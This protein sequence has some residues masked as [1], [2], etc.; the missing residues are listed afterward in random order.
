MLEAAAW[1][2]HTGRVRRQD[3]RPF[4]G[5]MRTECGFVVALPLDGISGA[6]LWGEIFTDTPIGFSYSKGMLLSRD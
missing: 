6:T 4:A 2:G 5:V 3:A 1:S